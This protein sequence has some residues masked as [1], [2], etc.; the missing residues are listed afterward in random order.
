MLTGE[1]ADRVGRQREEEEA[2]TNRRTPS[3]RA[4]ISICSVPSTLTAC[5]VNGSAIERGTDGSAA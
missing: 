5:D 1:L 3:S 4:A 2:N